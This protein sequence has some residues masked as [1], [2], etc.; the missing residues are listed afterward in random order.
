MKKLIM[1]VIKLILFICILCLVIA[2]ALGYNKYKSAINEINLTDK[3]DSIRDSTHYK[4]LD[5]I[6]PVFLEAIV[7]IEDHRFYEHGPIDFISLVRATIVNT[8][9]KDI[10]QGGST[11][12]QQVA[13]NLYFSNDQSYIRKVAEMFVARDLEKHYSKDEVLELYVNIIYYGD[14]NYGIKEASQNYFNKQPIDLSYDEATL[15]AGLP[16]S[17]SSYA[18]SKHYDRAKERQQEVINALKK[19]SKSE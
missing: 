16:Q 3:V 15:L 11:L 8:L 1:K 17:P 14:G 4:S 10:V 6:N 2:L 7:A 13:K 19:Y 12:T 5:E 18:L 9:Q